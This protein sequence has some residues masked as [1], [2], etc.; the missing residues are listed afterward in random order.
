MIVY[1]LIIALLIIS[2][3]TIQIVRGNLPLLDNFFEQ[4]LR[5][6]VSSE[7]IFYFFRFVTELGSKTFL[8][9]F[10]SLMAIVFFIIFRSMI[11]SVIFAGGTLLAHLINM[12]MKEI[13]QRERP[14]VWLEASAY[15][16]S[17][18]SGHAMISLVCYGLL[19]YF[20]SLK[21]KQRYKKQLLLTSFSLLI[22][23]IGISR[24]V[25]N[26]HYMTDIVS[27]FV[28]GY[29]LLIGFIYIARHYVKTK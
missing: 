6:Y 9:P 18:P 28:L 7:P 19:A 25:L 24:F 13:V 16:Y 14:L 2:Y 22:F 15:G 17:F 27:G 29:L 21:V 23:F 10:V 1:S 4:L 11:P 8:I 3:W 12:L 26:V 20:L 5:D